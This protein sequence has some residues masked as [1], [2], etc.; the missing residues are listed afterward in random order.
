[1]LRI[2]IFTHCWLGKQ[3]KRQAE[4]NWKARLILYGATLPKMASR[5]NGMVSLFVESYTALRD[6]CS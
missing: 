2:P 5:V 4:S 1:M 3:E 6:N